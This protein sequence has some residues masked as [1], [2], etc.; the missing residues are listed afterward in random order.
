MEQIGE[1]V[2]RV[3][4]L[5]QRAGVD[6]LLVN[7]DFMQTAAAFGLRRTADGVEMGT[8]PI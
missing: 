6:L 4:D 5:V 1:T 8:I 7:T 2:S 3:A